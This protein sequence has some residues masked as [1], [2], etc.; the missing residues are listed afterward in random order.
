[1]FDLLFIR[2]AFITELLFLPNVIIYGSMYIFPIQ[3]MYCITFQHPFFLG[4]IILSDFTCMFKYTLKYP[5]MHRN[6]TIYIECKSF[7]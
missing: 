6:K 2:K 1:M 5:T 3:I 7:R 4:N